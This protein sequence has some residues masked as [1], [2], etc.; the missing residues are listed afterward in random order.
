MLV[1]GEVSRHWQRRCQ[2]KLP[3]FFIS[4]A[5]QATGIAEAN[6]AIFSKNASPNSFFIMLKRVEE[7]WGGNLETAFGVLRK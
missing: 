7:V 3:H 4:H 1:Y 6:F 5:L 2:S